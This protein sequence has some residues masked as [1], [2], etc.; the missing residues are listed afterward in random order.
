MHLAHFVSALYGFTLSVSRAFWG[1]Q[2]S[3]SANGRVRRGDRTLRN[4]ASFFL[5]AMD[6]RIGR[7]TINLKNGHT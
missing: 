2:R 3:G 7:D 5:L 4:A 1:S 6:L